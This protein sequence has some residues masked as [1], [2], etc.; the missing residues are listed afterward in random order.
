MFEWEARYN[1]LSLLNQ[2]LSITREA[3]DTYHIR[4]SF[5]DVY[6]QLGIIKEKF[7]IEL[8]LNN[9]YKICVLIAQKYT[10]LVA[11]AFNYS[12]QV[13][14]IFIE[15]LLA[16]EILDKINLIGKIDKFPLRLLPT[17]YP[18]IP[19]LIYAGKLL[20][21]DFMKFV[22]GVKSQGP[23]FSLED[24]LSRKEAHSYLV[25]NN[26]SIG[27]T[28]LISADTN[29]NIEFPIYIWEKI[30]TFINKLGWNVCINDSGNLHNSKSNLITN[31]N[32]K[33]LKIPPH[34]P[35]SIS[36]LMGAYIAGSNGFMTIL[37]LFGENVKGVH[38]I[39]ALNSSNGHIKDKF[40]NLVPV[41]I[42][43]ANNSCQGSIRNQQLEIPIFYEKDLEFVEKSINDLLLGV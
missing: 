38:L 22:V 24:D 28:V 15:D 39:N 7:L 31:N 32:L 20:Q 14:C 26:I 16:N 3:N 41:E 35:V 1:Y 17:I 40:G 36:E 25:E 10:K 13:K 42:L 11:S 8:N 37:S 29:T 4:G 9:D 19:E 30:I 27:N 21:I 18:Y 5:G 2:I 12:N 43:Y 6:M 33:F 34:L 23:L